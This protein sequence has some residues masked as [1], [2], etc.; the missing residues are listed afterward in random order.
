M[1]D[2]WSNTD[3]TGLEMQFDDCMYSRNGGTPIAGI[4]SSTLVSE[5][6]TVEREG[7][8]GLVIAN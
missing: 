1:F 5:G 3:L 2:S 4:S 6:C 8:D 7:N